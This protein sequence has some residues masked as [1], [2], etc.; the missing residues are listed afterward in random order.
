[1]IFDRCSCP[2]LPENP[3]VCGD[4]SESL[5]NEEQELTSQ[6]QDSSL[7]KRSLDEIDDIVVLRTVPSATVLRKRRDQRTWYPIA[8]NPRGTSSPTKNR[9]IRSCKSI[10]M[11][12]SATR[13]VSIPSGW[14]P[15]KISAACRCRSG[16][17]GAVKL[18]TAGPVNATAIP[19][20]VDEAVRS[21]NERNQGRRHDGREQWGGRRRIQGAD[22]ETWSS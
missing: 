19:C 14:K 12:A 2:S 17:E 6:I 8:V 15:L 4:V 10:P 11:S 1:M 9:A 20:C 16:A 5:S 7:R 22:I 18:K 3:A 13:E 21:A